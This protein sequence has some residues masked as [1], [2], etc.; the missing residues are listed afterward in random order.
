MN[1]LPTRA[2][3]QARI[4]KLQ[5]IVNAYKS[6]EDCFGAP[7]C[8]ACDALEAELARM[9]LRDPSNNATP[10]ADFAADLIETMLAKKGGAA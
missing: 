7:A 1:K 9:G 6:A 10:A 3:M 2:E 5:G 4:D 8:E